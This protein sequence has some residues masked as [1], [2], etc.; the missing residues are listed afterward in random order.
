MSHLG[1]TCNMPLQRISH[2]TGNCHIQ[3]F[4]HNSVMYNKQTSDLAMTDHNKILSL[5]EDLIR[6]G[7]KQEPEASVKWRYEKD[8]L[9]F[10]SSPD[11]K[12]LPGLYTCHRFCTGLEN[13]IYDV[14]TLIIGWPRPGFFYSFPE[15]LE[16][17]ITQ[18]I[19]LH[20]HTNSTNAD[21]GCNISMEV[22]PPGS[23]PVGQGDGDHGKQSQP[24]WHCEGD[25][26]R[27]AAQPPAICYLKFWCRQLDC[28]VK[29]NCTGRDNA[30][31]I[32][33][34]YWDQDVSPGECE[35]RKN[36]SAGSG[37]VTDNSQEQSDSAKSKG[38]TFNHRGAES[39]TPPVYDHNNTD[40]LNNE[41]Q[42]SCIITA[43]ITGLVCI[44]ISVCGVCAVVKFCCK[45]AY[46]WEKVTRFFKCPQHPAAESCPDVKDD[47]SIAGKFS[48]NEG[49]VDE[50]LLPAE[51]A[52]STVA[53]VESRPGQGRSAGVK[54]A[55]RSS[56]VQI[57]MEDTES[58]S[59][60]EDGAS[61]AAEAVLKRSRAGRMKNQPADVE[62][63]ERGRYYD[64]NVIQELQV[65]DWVSSLGTKM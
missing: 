50:M 5:P 63:H 1:C 31:S 33:D 41:E 36:V 19:V 21:C 53:S 24:S 22:S 3:I 65:T 42:G 13:E 39:T 32:F 44:F 29:Y 15:G 20:C 55:E 37:T 12:D 47:G 7:Q 62:H 18:R 26:P 28:S 54:P 11:T 49:S 10:Q 45:F 16:C 64:P 27:S 59:E 17:K 57:E 56:S 2:M 40:E 38:D 35:F 43:G 60:L 46:C 61:A 34:C 48:S 52:A 4:K 23:C 25:E 14:K 8:Q 9:K 6:R 51:R 58:I 30:S